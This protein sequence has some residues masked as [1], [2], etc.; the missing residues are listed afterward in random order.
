MDD[1]KGSVLEMMRVVAAWMDQMLRLPNE[2]REK[3]A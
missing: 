1:L 2:A 3:T